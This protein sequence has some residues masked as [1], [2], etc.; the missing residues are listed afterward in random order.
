MTDRILANRGGGWALHPQ[1]WM[2]FVDG[3]NLTIR[4]QEFLKE[5]GV[6]L[7]EGPC[8]KRDTFLWVRDLPGTYNL[9]DPTHPLQAH[10]A[11]AY[12]YTTLV[13]DADARRG[14]SNALKELGF[15]PRVFARLQG[16]AKAKGSTSPSPPTSLATRFVTI[17]TLQCWWPETPTTFLCWTRSSVWA[18]S[19][20]LPSSRTTA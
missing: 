6:E 18:S 11:R 12:Y 9:A 1:R 13:G 5:L 14:V 2:L 19:R 16:R 3:E 20:T 10:A 17:L 8:Y 4:A 7:Q 15:T